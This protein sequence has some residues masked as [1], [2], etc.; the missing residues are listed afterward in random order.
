MD[1]T[2]AMLMAIDEGF[3]SVSQNQCMAQC[4]HP[5]RHSRRLKIAAAMTPSPNTAPAA[6]HTLVYSAA[7]LQLMNIV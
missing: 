1:I 4:R 2:V 6:T 7:T 3:I 5:K